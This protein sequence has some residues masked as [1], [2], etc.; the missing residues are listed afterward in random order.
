MAFVKLV[1]NNAHFK[2]YQ[3]KFRRRREGKTDYRARKRLV[4]QDKNKFNTPKYRLVVRLSN[5]YVMCQITWATIKGDQVLCTATSKELPE[6]YG[7]PG[8]FGLKNWAACYAT[9]LLL[10]RRVLNKLDLDKVYQ[11][12]TEAD[13]EDYQVEEA[14]EGAR[15]FSVCLDVG[16]QTTSTGARCFGALKGAL[17]GGLSIPHNVRRWPACEKDQCDAEQVRKYIFAG[18][19]GEYME[20]MEEDDEEMYKTHFAQ[21][22][23]SDVTAENMEETWAKVHETIRASPAYTKTAKHPPTKPKTRKLKL[24][25]AQRQD[26]VRQ[27]I[28]A[29]IAKNE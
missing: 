13:G 16:L 11:G 4:A 2:R 12:Q 24:N 21:Y 1:K 14:D 15:P 27:K 17:D 10:A 9:G 23:E 29:H 3:T 18:H 8:K 5:R 7:L 26:R 28:T 22:L 25:A 19:V 6:K 20:A